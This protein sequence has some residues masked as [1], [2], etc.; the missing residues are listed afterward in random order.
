LRRGDRPIARDWA[1]SG[2]F[3]YA[4]EDSDNCNARFDS[5]SRLEE[6]VQSGSLCHFRMKE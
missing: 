5:L 6:M 4:D 1:V 2:H 3:Q